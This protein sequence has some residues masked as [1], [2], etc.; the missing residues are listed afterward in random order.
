MVSKWTTEASRLVLDDGWIKV[1]ADRCT[2]VDGQVIDPYYVI[3]AS[4]W[5][6]ILPPD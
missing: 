3:C 2:G 6:S 1:R 4:D 5:V